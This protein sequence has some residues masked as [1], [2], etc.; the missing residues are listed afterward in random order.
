MYIV[1]GVE[2]R[3]QVSELFVLVLLAESHGRRTHAAILPV[4]VRIYGTLSSR[5]FSFR[6]E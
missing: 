3:N 4:L 1:D 2:N 6:R 5:G